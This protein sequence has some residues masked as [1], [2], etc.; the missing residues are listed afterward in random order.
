M[1]G[2]GEEKE[3]LLRARWSQ[4]TRERATTDR[5]SPLTLSWPPLT[6]MLASSTI[7]ER[8]SNNWERTSRSLNSTRPPRIQ[9]GAAA[10]PSPARGRHLAAIPGGEGGG[11]M[12]SA[13]HRTGV[14]FGAPRASCGTTPTPTR[15]LE[16]IQKPELAAL[17][18]PRR[19]CVRCCCCWGVRG[20][21]RRGQI[22][23]QE[24]LEV[25]RG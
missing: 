6:G 14:F 13:V 7:N 1:Q 12:S 21:A 16:R 9:S 8:R 24:S 5:L 11:D 2:R 20:L 19:R 15:C 25:E 18:V 22:N 17:G 23:D 10:A 3:G 4:M